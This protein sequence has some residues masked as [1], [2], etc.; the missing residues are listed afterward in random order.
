[1]FDGVKSKAMTSNLSTAA[2]VHLNRMRLPECIMDDH[3]EWYGRGFVGG[4]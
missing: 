1:M 2:G 4:S 3:V